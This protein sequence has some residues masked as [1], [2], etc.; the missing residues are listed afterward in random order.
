VTASTASTADAPITATSAPPRAGPT[1]LVVADYGCDDEPLRGRVRRKARADQEADREQDGVTQAANRVEQG[2]ESEQRCAPGV[3]DQH[4]AARA[5]RVRE[6]AAR[7]AEQCGAHEL[8]RH[9]PG[10]AGRRAGGDEDEPRQRDRGHLSAGHGHHLGDQD[11]AQSPVP[12]YA[13]G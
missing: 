11:R 7:D 10:H 8:G 1:K 9:D 3:G 12:P 4:G 2:D 5:E 6:P 13:H